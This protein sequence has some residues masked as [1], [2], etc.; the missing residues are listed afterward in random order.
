MQS[1]DLRAAGSF[2]TTT[3]ATARSCIRSEERYLVWM[4]E[5]IG[6]VYSMALS[7]VDQGK[8]VEDRANKAR[9]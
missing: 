2:R 5:W 8:R 1:M 4:G 9:P 7:R 6:C 3:Q